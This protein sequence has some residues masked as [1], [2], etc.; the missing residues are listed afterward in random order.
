MGKRRSSFMRFWDDKVY[1]SIAI[2]GVLLLARVKVTTTTA[3]SSSSSSFSAS[4]KRLVLS[5]SSHH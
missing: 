1:A 2:M 3:S 4:T 5:L